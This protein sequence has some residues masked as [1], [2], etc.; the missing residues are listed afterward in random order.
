MNPI[1][2]GHNR[3]WHK[4]EQLNKS[5]EKDTPI[6]IILR[7]KNDFNGILSAAP[8]QSLLLQIA[9]THKLAIQTIEDARQFR[10]MLSS[11][12]TNT[13]LLVIMAHGYPDKI[14]F[15]SN[16]FWSRWLK[17]PFYYKERVAKEDFESLKSDAKIILYA[18]TTG[19]GIA[20]TI[21][22]LSNR[23]VYAPTESLIDT[24][25]CLQKCPDSSFQIVSY[26]EN[27]NQ[28]MRVFYPN[29]SSSFVSMDQ[30]FSDSNKESLSEMSD[31]LK[32]EALSG[33]INAQWKLGMF[34][35][36]GIGNC[37]K[38]AQNAAHWLGL[39]ASLGEAQAQFELGNL[40]FLG[41]EGIEKSEQKAKELFILSANQEHPYAL[42]QIGVFCLN[43][44]CG[45]QRSDE[46]AA[47]FFKLAL[48]KG[49]PQAL[50]NLGILY[51]FGRGVPRSLNYAKHLYKIADGLSIPGANERLLTLS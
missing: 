5:K 10:A 51:E 25:T 13:S 27:N 37:Q 44:N 12:G 35:L 29:S 28:H 42:F 50:F 19:K 2:I 45:F 21:A 3:F 26:D 23:I 17:T 11:I 49:V 30:M 36:L 38:S 46:K 24:K 1:E 31:Y 20:Q 43:G 18:C 8:A 14:Q 33:N 34:Y 6:A 9:K 40:Y 16:T 48:K 32:E 4:L 39:A 47:S 41:T 7:A 15:G 22:N